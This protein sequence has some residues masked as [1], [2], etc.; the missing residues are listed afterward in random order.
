MSKELQVDATIK[1]T[2]NKTE[3]YLT[4]EQARKLVNDLSS[5]TGQN[6]ENQ[7]SPIIIERNRDRGPWGPWPVTTYLRNGDDLYS[8][9]EPRM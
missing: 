4:M 3:I 2:V 1:V 5:I 7:H 8:D 6:T 9:A